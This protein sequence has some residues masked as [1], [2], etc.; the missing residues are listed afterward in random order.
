VLSLVPSDAPDSAGTVLCLQG[1]Q[2]QLTMK[3]LASV[4]LHYLLSFANA[5]GRH[6]TKQYDRQT[7]KLV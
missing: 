5:E 2:G 3:A 4:A 1:H 7:I 6:R